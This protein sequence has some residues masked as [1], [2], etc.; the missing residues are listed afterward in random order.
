MLCLLK[1]SYS[2]VDHQ[3]CHL[4]S[5]ISPPLWWALHY[6]SLVWRWQWEKILQ[7]WFLLLFRYIDINITLAVSGVRTR[8]GLDRFC[9]IPTVPLPSKISLDVD[10]H[11]NRLLLLIFRL[12]A[13]GVK[14]WTSRP[15]QYPYITQQAPKTWVHWAEFKKKKY[16]VFKSLWNICQKDAINK[17][18]G[19]SLYCKSLDKIFI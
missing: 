16:R 19:F 6:N 17:I 5:L 13:A 2:L 9:G 12:G 8:L 1:R 15:N 3:C 4:R 18:Q 7:L 14:L 11:W 10:Y